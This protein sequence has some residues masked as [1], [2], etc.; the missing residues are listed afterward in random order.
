MRREEKVGRASSRP[1]S[2]GEPHFRLVSFQ[3]ETCCLKVHDTVG[4]KKDYPLY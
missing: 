2:N 3:N 1:E 4:N